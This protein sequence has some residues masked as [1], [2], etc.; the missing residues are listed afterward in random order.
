MQ[1]SASQALDHKTG[2]A[3]RPYRSSKPAQA[4][5]RC[6]AVR[7]A[8]EVFYDRFAIGDGVQDRGSVRNRFIGRDAQYAADGF[9]SRDGP[10]HLR[11]GLVIGL[12]FCSRLLLGALL[13]KFLQVAP[14]VLSDSLSQSRPS[15]TVLL[16]RFLRLAHEFREL[17]RSL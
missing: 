14:H 6:Q 4:I 9:R 13:L 12:V 1:P 17:L 11:S 10:L 8:L 15:F 16:V 7:A 5:E 2:F 3:T